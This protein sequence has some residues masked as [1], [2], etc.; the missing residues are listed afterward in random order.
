MVELHLTTLPSQVSLEPSSFTQE[1][2]ELYRKYQQ[3]IHHEEEE[4]QPEAFERFLVTTPLDVG[5]SHLIKLLWTKLRRH[6]LQNPSIEY[7]STPPDHLPTTY[8]SYHQVR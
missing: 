8:G 4:K 2:F 7:A 1:K 5:C 3:D 6:R